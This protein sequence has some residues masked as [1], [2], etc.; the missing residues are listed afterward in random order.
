MDEA[1]NFIKWATG[2]NAAEIWVDG[3]FLPAVK[4]PVM[5]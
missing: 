1:F 5:S 4:D 3:G 2:P